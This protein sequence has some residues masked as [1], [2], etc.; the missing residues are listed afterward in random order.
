VVSLDLYKAFLFIGEGGGG[1]GSLQILVVVDS[2]PALLYL[3]EGGFN[4]SSGVFFIFHVTCYLLV[5]STHP[6]R[7]GGVNRD[8]TFS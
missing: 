7:N 5:S 2:L 4:L 6:F 3:V 8:I 1:L